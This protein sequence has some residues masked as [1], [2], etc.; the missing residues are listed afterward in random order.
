LSRKRL[1]E[2]LSDAGLLSPAQVQEILLVQKATGR[3][4]GTIALAKGWLTKDDIR[5][6]LKKQWGVPLIDLET[7]TPVPEILKLIPRRFAQKHLIVPVRMEGGVMTV[8]T[9]AP[10]DL[11][12]IDSISVLTGNDVTPVVA[13]EEEIL[14]YIRLHYRHEDISD[15]LAGMDGKGA[16]LPPAPPSPPAVPDDPTTVAAREK[17][18]VRA[19]VDEVRQEMIGLSQY[20]HTHPEVSLKEYQSVT[21][22][23][24]FL[25]ERGFAVETGVGGLETSFLARWGNGLPGPVIAFIAEYDALPEVG[26]ACG[27]NLIAGAALGAALAVRSLGKGVP[28]QVLVIGTPAEEMGAGKA[29][30][31]KNGVFAGVDAC[32]MFHPGPRTEIAKGSL[33]LV[34]ARIK[35]YGQASH[36]AIS[37]QAGRNALEA[38]IQGFCLANSLRQ[39]LPPG[40]RADGI[41]VEGGKAPNIIPDYAEAEFFLRAATL[42]E[43]RNLLERFRDLWAG[44]ATATGCDVDVEISRDVILPLKINPYLAF[45]FLRN[46]QAIGVAAEFGPGSTP[47]GSTDAGNLS[48]ELPVLHPYLGLGDEAVPMHSAGF[49]R[50][51]GSVNGHQVMTTAAKALAMTGVDLLFDPSALERVRGDFGKE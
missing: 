18:R 29:A 9:V 15:I 13:L 49:S 34:E 32:L 1:G 14:D 6:A 11:T 42:Q 37:P 3:M 22:L 28:G 45:L 47:P 21:H 20:L 10:V 46:L 30:M 8:A 12:V 40:S 41:I 33:A 7:V 16:E 4:F 35:A 48:Q 23:A 2:I 25:A 44:V 39:T 38:I 26:H 17:L 19:A 24:N 31:M 50:L 51:V 43:L 5:I 27:H 36:A